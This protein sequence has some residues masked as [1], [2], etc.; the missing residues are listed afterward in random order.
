[1]W[2]R[3]GVSKKKKKGD[4][5]GVGVLCHKKVY[6][7]AAIYTVGRFSGFFTA[8]QKVAL[9]HRCFIGL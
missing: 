7:L 9:V 5:G 2:V 1:M 4:W 6:L 8:K 3:S